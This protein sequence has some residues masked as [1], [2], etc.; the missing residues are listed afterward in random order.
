MGLGMRREGEEA[1]AEEQHL[2]RVVLE[3]KLRERMREN[4]KLNQILML[5]CMAEDQLRVWGF[6]GGLGREGWQG[7]EGAGIIPSHLPQM[8]LIPDDPS[9]SSAAGAAGNAL[10]KSALQS[11]F[12]ANVTSIKNWEVQ[13]RLWAGIAA[14]YVGFGNKSHFFP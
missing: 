14:E 6:P 10:P 5:E 4:K 11:H 9:R 7:L 2:A 8:Q 1:E 3:E 13:C 12:H